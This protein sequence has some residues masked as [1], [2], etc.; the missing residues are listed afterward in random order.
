MAN[1]NPNTNNNPHLS[2]IHSVQNLDGNKKRT[3]NNFQNQDEL[4]EEEESLVG[5]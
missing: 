4:K 1:P 2:R 5:P 3:F